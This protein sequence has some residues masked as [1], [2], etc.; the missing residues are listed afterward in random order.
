MVEVMV[1]MECYQMTKTEYVPCDRELFKR[2]D[3]LLRQVKT[4]DGRDVIELELR[5][6]DE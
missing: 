6:C 4:P 2:D 1:W 3:R 5:P